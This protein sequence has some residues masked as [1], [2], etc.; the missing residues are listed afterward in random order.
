[1]RIIYLT[2]NEESALHFLAEG[3]SSLF[4]KEHC[5]LPLSGMGFFLATLRRKTGIL[6][7]RQP[8]ECRNYISRYVAALK[9][10]PTAEQLNLLKRVR[11]GDSL[12]AISH[13]FDI[14][15]TE[16]YRRYDEAC[17]AI[18]IFAKEERARRMSILI[19]L[20]AFGEPLRSLGELQLRALRLLADGKSYDEISLLMQEKLSYVRYLI[21]DAA[22]RL[23]LSARGRDVQRNLIRAYLARKDAAVSAE[24]AAAQSPSEQ[25]EVS[26]DDPAFN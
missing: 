14:T 4:I 8:S 22:T 23:S 5:D 15:L 19:Y 26:M 13:R 18:G 7:I 21:K 17:A 16:L 11:H 9:T 6:N 24:A 20:S 25:P 2:E 12:E 10:P 1:M 3:K